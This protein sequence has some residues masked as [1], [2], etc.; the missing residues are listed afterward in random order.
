MNHKQRISIEEK[1]LPAF[2]NHHTSMIYRASV[3]SKKSLISFRRRNKSQELVAFENINKHDIF[4][5]VYKFVGKLVTDS[6]YT[7]ELIAEMEFHQDENEVCLHFSEK[8]HKW[9][10]VDSQD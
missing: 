6:H 2:M 5:I 4:N 3:N 8:S 7:K 10:S 9:S 1:V